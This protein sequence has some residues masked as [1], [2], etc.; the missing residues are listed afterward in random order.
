ME[1]TELVG[2]TRCKLLVVGCWLSVVDK[3][4]KAS[5]SLEYLKAWVIISNAAKLKMGSSSK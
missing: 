2:I 3:I 5:F 4:R 1:H